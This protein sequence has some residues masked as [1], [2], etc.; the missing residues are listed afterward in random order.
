MKINMKRL[1][2]FGSIDQI[3]EF[4]NTNKNSGL[5]IEIISV[6]DKYQCVSEMLWNIRFR[7]LSK[8]DRHIVFKLLNF[9][10]GYSLSHAK[11]LATKW[12]GGTLAFNP[13]RRRHKFSRKY[14]PA[15]I[16]LLIETDTAHSC[17]SGEATGEILKREFKIFKRADYANISHIS[18]A[19]IYN[20]RNR[21]RQYNSSQAKFFKRT[22]A[23]D[24]DIGVRRKPR[25]NGRPGYVRVDTV[26]QGDYL[27]NKG[28]YH[29]NIVDEVTQYELIATVEQ[30]TERY[31][32]PVVEA[33]LKLFPFAI[34]EFHADNGSE[35]INRWVVEL[36]NKI[37]IDLTKSRSR[38]SNDNALVESKN[39]SVIR[40]MYGRNYIDRKW[41][42][43]INEFNKNYV[44]IYL[45]YHR[46]CAFAVYE[47]DKLGKLRKKYK[48]R[49][50]PYEKLKS[51]ENAEQY[52]KQDFSF[53]LLDKIAYAKSDNQFAEE[54][55]EA[56]KKLFKKISRDNFYKNQK[57][58][59]NKNPLDW[60]NQK[61]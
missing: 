45:N 28:V 60:L 34:F 52:L 21:N 43:E 24:I 44:N 1:P 55:N 32:K 18:P 3:R 51:L 30:I 33:L 53:T 54:M 56:K 50:V 11:R 7:R 41:A 22:T 42:D 2:L 59:E 23:R 38:H 12:R 48:Q 17:L 14:Y 29:I 37:H 47:P 35:Y 61:G 31:L 40:K 10:T 13:S 9:F 19:H 26:H 20:I 49:M 36:L 4:L 57:Q 8:T 15:D 46:P 6:R 27:G 5:K 58:T 25:P 16:A 39:G